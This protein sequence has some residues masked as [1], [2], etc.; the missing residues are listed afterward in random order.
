MKSLIKISLWGAVCF[1]SFIAGATNLLAENIEPDQVKIYVH[2]DSSFTG[3]FN[4]SDIFLDGRKIY[5]LPQKTSILFLCK[6]GEHSVRSE[7]EKKVLTFNTQ[8]GTEYHIQIKSGFTGFY[9]VMVTDAKAIADL[10]GLEEKELD[11]QAILSTPAPPWWKKMMGKAFYFI[12]CLLLMMAGYIIIQ[13][14]INLSERKFGDSSDIMM[15]LFIIAGVAVTAILGSIPYAYVHKWI[16]DGLRMVHAL[17]V[18]L[19]ALVFSFL[20]VGID[21]HEPIKIFLISFSLT[22]LLVF[23]LSL[24]MIAG[25][26]HFYPEAI[27][28]IIAM[29]IWKTIGFAVSIVFAIVMNIYLFI[30]LGQSRDLSGAYETSTRGYWA[31][32][33]GKYFMSAKKWQTGEWRSPLSAFMRYLILNLV[34]ATLLFILVLHL[35]IGG[36]IVYFVSLGLVFLS[37][38][39]FAVKAG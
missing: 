24:S 27:R 4:K 25:L 35:Q 28:L 7:N 19:S 34:F 22:A 15:V 9:P 23:F 6:P 26:N 13:L 21:P 11:L 37:C 2:R 10:K 12:A 5:E 18:L 20:I 17:F 33:D 3:A 32:Q 8:G 31:T 14:F 1:L 38:V 29:G 30:K 39:I 36:L 16:P